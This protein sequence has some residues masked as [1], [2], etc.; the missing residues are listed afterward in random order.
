MFDKVEGRMIDERDLCH[1]CLLYNLLLRMSD[2][3]PWKSTSPPV[4]SKNVGQMQADSWDRI[5]YL[6]LQLIFD[7]GER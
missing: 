3:R 2:A 7:D 5:N 6:S 1:F 4:G